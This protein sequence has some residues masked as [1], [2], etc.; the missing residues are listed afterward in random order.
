M[1]RRSARPFTVEVKHTRTSRAS[2]TDATAR[3]REGQNLWQGLALVADDKPAEVQPMQSAP[4]ARS[5]PVQAEAPA[6][7]VLP[8]LVPTFAMPIEAEAQEVREAPA[9][10]RLPR[11]RRPKQLTKREQKPTTKVVAAQLP[12][13]ESATQPGVT[14]AVAS[15]SA[16]TP[17]VVARPAAILA[18]SGRR[19]QQA[20]TL[21]PGERW[22]RR[23]PRALW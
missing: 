21:R 12:R 20:V 10:E 16:E 2:L 15:T 13:A 19:T 8:S 7:C 17:A 1:K 9:A 11:V 5:E 23:L 6:R 3:S 22:K 4:V 14:P 18:R